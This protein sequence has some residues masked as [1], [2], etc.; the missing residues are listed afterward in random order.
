MLFNSAVFGIFFVIVYSLYLGLGKHLKAQNLMLLVASYVFYGW[1]DWRFLF[2]IFAST[3][4][5]YICGIKI[6]EAETSIGKKRYLLVSLI[7]NLTF[8]GFFKYF[9]FF[10]ENA[11]YLLTSLGFNPHLETL[12]I[13][14]PV[15]ISFYTFQT[16]SYSIDVY[17]GVM[18]PERSF[19]RFAL[20]V[21][22]FPQLVA[23]PI[24]RAVDLVPQIAN[25]RAP[26]RSDQELGFWLMIW[27]LFKKVVVADNCAQISDFVYGMPAGMGGMDVII[28]NLFFTFQIYA[29][30][31]GYSDMAIGMARMMGFHFKLNFNLPYF[32]KNP[33]DFWERWHM[34]LSSWFKDYLYFPMAMYYGRKSNHFL[35]RYK[36]H[37]YSMALIGFWHGAQW[38]YLFFGVY[39]GLCIIAYT[40][41]RDVLKKVPVPVLMAGHFVLIWI[42]FVIFRARNLDQLGQL[43][44]LTVTDFSKNLSH[45]ASYEAGFYIFL[46]LVM[47]VIQ[48][49]KNDLNFV[50]SLKPY[51]RTIVY[52]LVILFVAVSG[53]FTGQ[54]F[55]YFQF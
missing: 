52:G 33:V 47:Q 23:G 44:W 8:L 55:I 41:L 24:V 31:S 9:D 16:M 27:G 36:A 53:E 35:N 18:P 12:G 29:D 11:A 14:L 49:K 39:W 15:G 54:Q 22:F 1:W 32:A 26:T 46:L 25:E 42:G 6:H 17:R 3:L 48:W 10:I 51:K 38:T 40:R 45:P 7:S 43:L 28:G 34:S 21:A 4:I 2:L 37:L 20:F 19:H 50:L 5:D 13:I 30:F